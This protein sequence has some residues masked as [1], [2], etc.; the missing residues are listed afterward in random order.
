[1]RRVGGH[2]DVAETSVFLALHPDQVR[3]GRAAAGYTGELDETVIARIMA[4]GFDSV[5]PNGVIGDP[6]GATAAIGEQCIDSMVD[7]LADHF[8]SEL[9]PTR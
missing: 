8:T 9:R 1:M 2:A 5:S 6:E 4:D 3:D 7:L